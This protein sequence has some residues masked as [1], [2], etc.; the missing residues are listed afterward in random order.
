MGE[1]LVHT[2]HIA[3]FA[4]ANTD[5]TCWHIDIRTDM[6]GQ[7]QHEGLAEAHH[8]GTRLA[9]WR[10]VGTT[11]GTSHRQGR[12]AVLERLLEC[13]ELED[14]E[15]DTLMEAD[16][17]LVRANDIVVLHAVAHVRL[18]V[19]LIVHPVYT[20]LIDTVGDTET[21]D[22]IHLLELGVLVVLLFNGAEDFFHCLM[23]FRLVG[24]SLLQILQYFFCFH[25]LKQ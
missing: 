13:K 14:T 20:E 23:I 1:F 10:E 7:F 11:L 24:E 15:I 25:T 17:S 9:T 2:E 21:L 8:L 22:E 12:Q 19:T 5:I 16:T 18:Y 3:H 4:A 6:A